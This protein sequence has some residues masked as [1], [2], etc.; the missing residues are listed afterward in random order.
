MIAV[1]QSGLPDLLTGLVGLGSV[2]V[3]LM[4]LVAIGGLAYRSMT[5]GV[6]WPDER[7]EDDDELR[8][9]DSDDEWDYY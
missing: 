3:L 8:R 6:E 7:Q 2:V 4:I 1:L 9:G 5:G